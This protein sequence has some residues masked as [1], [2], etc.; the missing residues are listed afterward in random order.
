MTQAPGG[1]ATLAGRAVAR[2]GYGA[3]QLED[4]TAERTERRANAVAVLRRA[5]ELGVDHVDTAHFY[6]AANEAIR[7]ALAPYDDLALVG[8]V[9]AVRTP[10][11]GLT[12]AQRPEQ[13]REQVEL[14]LS[15]LGTDH[16]AVVNLRRADAP[17]GIVATGDQLVDLDDQLAAL[18]ALR[19]A[20]TIG[21]I[22]LS[23]VDAAQL[24]RALPAGVACVQ[25]WHNLLDRVW[26]PVLDV[27]R[28]HDIAWVP[29]FPLGSAFSQYPNVTDDPRVQ[30]VAARR[31]VTPAQV[32]LAWELAHYRGT[33]LIPG[34]ANVGHLE[35]NVAAG[36]VVLDGSDLAELDA[37]DAGVRSA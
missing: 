10:D 35:E 27:C 11:G 7:E 6:G 25:N 20:G 14:T 37:P 32:G 36:D 13:L 3:M 17:P 26:E 31:G 9:G 34:T 30:R 2:V 12:A 15:Q 19:D 1:T 8:K 21:G 24:R 5:R 4:A 28:E 22:G 29:F 16:L 23:N 18:I 33:L